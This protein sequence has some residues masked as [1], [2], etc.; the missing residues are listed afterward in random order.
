MEKWWLDKAYLETR[1]PLAPYCNFTGPGPE[2]KL[3]EGKQ[4]ENLSMT[5]WYML[6]Y[7]KLATRYAKC[8]IIT[9]CCYISLQ[10]QAIFVFM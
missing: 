7:H 4:V 5:V 9:M 3:E 10:R 1:A 8:L 2:Y 6:Q